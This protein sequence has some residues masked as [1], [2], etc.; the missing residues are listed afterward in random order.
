MSIVRP[1]ASFHVERLKSGSELHS[2]QNYA[3]NPFSEAHFK[4]FKYRPAYPTRFGSYEDALAYCRA[5]F[6]WYNAHHRHA[7]IAMLT[8]D[9]VH[10]GRADEVLLARQ[11]VLDQAYAANPERF[12]NGPSIVEDLA[13]AVWINPPEDKTRTELELH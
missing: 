5:F 6:A 10:H 1:L 3:F 7:G 4:T 12:V 13:A 9:I 11:R 2:C 8:P